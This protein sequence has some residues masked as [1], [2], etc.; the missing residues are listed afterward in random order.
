[1]GPLPQIHGR[2]S[3]DSLIVSSGPVN[4]DI[5][6]LSEYQ[7]TL[8]DTVLSLRS[9]GWLDHQ[10]AK[11]FNNAG[12]LT[13]RGHSFLPQSVYSIRIKYERRLER[14]GG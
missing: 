13:P 2:E 14:L 6:P 10:I 8:I 11:H 4:L 1:M 3:P 7:K 12:Y 9:R 5:R